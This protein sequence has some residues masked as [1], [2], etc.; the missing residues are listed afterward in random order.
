M[1]FPMSCRTCIPFVRSVFAAGVTV[2]DVEKGRGKRIF[3]PAGWLEHGM[4][5]DMEAGLIQRGCNLFSASQPEESLGQGGG[6]QKALLSHPLGIS[7]GVVF[8]R[9]CQRFVALLVLSYALLIQAFFS[10]V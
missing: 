2:K 9:G 7:T 4:L 8:E 10:G 6:S 3:L 1:K 5:S